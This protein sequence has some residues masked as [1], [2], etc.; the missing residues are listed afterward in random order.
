MIAARQPPPELLST[1]L[2][3][4]FAG[5]ASAA[6][7]LA[8]TLLLPAIEA[9]VSKYLFG[10]ARQF[11][12]KDDL[13]QE[14][15]EH[16]CKNQWQKLR[17]YDQDRGTLE[18]FLFEVSRSWIRDNSRR[19][20]PPAP[21][22]DMDEHEVPDS[23]PENALQLSRAMERVLTVLDENELLLFRWVYLEGLGRA[24][25]AGRVQLSL[26]ATYK[27]IQRMETKVKGTLSNS[28]KPLRTPKGA[29]P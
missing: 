17:L 1:L 14:V 20:P 11:F 28:E 12:E 29:Q 5:S 15:F 21:V 22:E 6:R 3:Q 27:R 7:T 23:G 19:R 16:L 10:R 4:T 8:E 13:V 9:A 2:S 26:E 25:V 24:E 18:N